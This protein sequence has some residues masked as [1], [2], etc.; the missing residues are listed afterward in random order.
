MTRDIQDNSAERNPRLYWQVRNF[1][2]KVENARRR[3]LALQVEARRLGY[4]ETH[5]QL[6]AVNRVWNDQE[7]R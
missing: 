3:V 6:E 5:A 7:A 1:P 4:A 2:Q